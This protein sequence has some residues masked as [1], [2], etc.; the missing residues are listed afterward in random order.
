[1]KK[2]FAIG[3][4]LILLCL[5]IWKGKPLYQHLMARRLLRAAE[6][7]TAQGN[8]QEALRLFG[9]ALQRNPN[10]LFILQRFAALLD[11]AHRPEVL[12]FRARISQLQP[13]NTDAILDLAECALMYQNT[14][15]ARQILFQKDRTELQG[16]ARY[17]H[18]RSVLHF[19]S[20]ELPEADADCE[21][22]IRLEPSNQSFQVNQATIRL[23]APNVA[24]RQKAIATLEAVPRAS[25]SRFTA[26]QSLLRYSL[27]VSREPENLDRWLGEFREVIAPESPLFTLYLSALNRWR[28]EQFP[29]E[30][31]TYWKAAI[32]GPESA[33]FAQKW[34][35]ENGFYSDFIAF[36]KSLPLTWQAVPESLLLQADAL[37]AL[38]KPEELGQL[39]SEP[40]WNS[41]PPLKLAWEERLRR[42]SQAGQSEAD[43]A[44]WTAILSTTGNHPEGLTRLTELA[45]QWH[46]KAEYERSL[47]MLVEKIPSKASEALES[48]SRFYV[49]T[50]NGAGLFQVFKKQLSVHPEN[51]A[52]QNNVAFLSFLLGIETTRAERLASELTRRF[53]KVPSYI[54]TAAFGKLQAGE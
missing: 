34:F 27:L 50:E 2:R 36:R 15:L 51:V 8:G 4:I 46:W 33:I 47:W 11:Q 24:A 48:L 9:L 23:A 19:I 42:G 25:P 38:Q 41:M 44:K 49:G 7:A 26:L 52:L 28:R 17:Y 18:L 29:A 1:M 22:A 3:L 12:Q 20:K 45:Y 13:G 21:R 6:K 35:I 43:L 53:P 14:P 40:A 16:K 30:R 10:D 32:A 39:L 31:D 37:Y 5:A 54:A